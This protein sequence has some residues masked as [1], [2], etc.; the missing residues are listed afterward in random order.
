MVTNDKNIAG[1]DLC[2]VVSAGF[3]WFSILVISC[4]FSHVTI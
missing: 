3:F 1:V 2:T 4:Y